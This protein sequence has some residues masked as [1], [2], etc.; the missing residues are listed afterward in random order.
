[1]GSPPSSNPM[2]YCAQK[3]RHWANPVEIKPGYWQVEEGSGPRASVRRLAIVRYDGA[4]W[5]YKGWVDVWAGGSRGQLQ[6]WLADREWKITGPTAERI[7]QMVALVK[8]YG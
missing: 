2:R 5:R 8:E 1:M 7:E 4:Y 6:L 3:R